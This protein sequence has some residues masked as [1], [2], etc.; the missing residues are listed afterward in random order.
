MDTYT[1]SKR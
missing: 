1:W